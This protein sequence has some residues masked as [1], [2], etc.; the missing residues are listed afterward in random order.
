[1]GLWVP[2]HSSGAFVERNKPRRRDRRTFYGRDKR[3][4]RAT[5]VA[6]MQTADLRE[7]DDLAGTEWVYR[8]A[9]RTILVEREMRSRF[10][11]ILK[12]GRQHAAQVTLTEDDDVIEALAGAPSQ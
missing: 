9:L 4:S 12:V 10:V 1:V 8:T 2:L 5:L 3:L 11:V 7:R 6:M